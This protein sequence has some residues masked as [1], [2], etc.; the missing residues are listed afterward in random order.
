MGRAL[1]CWLAGLLIGLWLAVAD[2]ARADQTDPRL[3]DLFTNLKV[4]NG[5]AEA[6]AV[7]QQIW[8][9]WLATED[10]ARM[11]LMHSGLVALSSGNY[12]AALGSFDRLIAAAPDFAEAWNKRATVH[13]LMGR[14]SASVGD[15]ERAL[16]LEPRHFG[17]L[18]GLG[19]IYD[20]LGQPAAALRSFEAA[21]K[22]HP[23]LEA[24]RE[25]AA[26]LREQLGGR[27]I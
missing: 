11:R 1:G 15:I 17:A 2:V 13:Y 20:A 16:A 27:P 10:Q 24:P 21:L 9:I 6:A 19:L 3:P 18:S 14:L 7:E 22:V 5:A 4:A 26:A 8:R 25:R 23:F 12:P